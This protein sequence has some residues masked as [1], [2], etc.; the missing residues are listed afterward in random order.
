MRFSLAI[1]AAT[2][3]L[4]VSAPAL[5]D[6][7]RRGPPPGRGGYQEVLRPAIIPPAPEF[8]RRGHHQP[9]W[10][11]GYDRGYGRGFNRCRGNSGVTGAVL[12]AVIGGVLG[13]QIAGRGD[14]TMGTVIGAG[15]GAV[16]GSAIE[17]SSRDRRCR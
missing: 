15:V 7:W 13:D 8:S 1:V 4:T 9:G 6:D 3:L 16:A 17:R 5:A 11:G 14:R 2:S 10:H 12:G